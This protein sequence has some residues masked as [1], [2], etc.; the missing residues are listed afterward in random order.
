[1]TDTLDQWLQATTQAIEA[2]P[3]PPRFG[4][5]ICTHRTCILGCTVCDTRSTFGGDCPT[6]GTPL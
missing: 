2:Q 4:R 1:M 3:A 5:C 6:T